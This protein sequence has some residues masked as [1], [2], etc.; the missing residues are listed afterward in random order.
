MVRLSVCT[1]RLLRLQGR[2]FM[3]PAA[4]DL[5]FQSSLLRT[6]RSGSV[7]APASSRLASRRAPSKLRSRRSSQ[8]FAWILRPGFRAKRAAAPSGSARSISPTPKNVC[9][10]SA[11]TVH[12]S[13]TRL[14]SF[15]ASSSDCLP[16]SSPGPGVRRS[17]CLMRCHLRPGCARILTPP[18]R[19]VTGSTP[20]GL[21]R[22]AGCR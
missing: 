14:T 16:S 12:T 21:R 22:S 5:Q 4:T 3:Q 7:V 2:L 19:C 1:V 10:R 8:T 11:M 20:T 15:A 18:I 9:V 17:E 6:L 13:A